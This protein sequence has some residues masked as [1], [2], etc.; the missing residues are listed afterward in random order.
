MS[1][2]DAATWQCALLE[3]AA[4]GTLL[5]FQTANER[6]K[7]KKWIIGSGAWLASILLTNSLFACPTCKEGLLENGQSGLNLARGFELSIY[8][9]LSAPLLILS[10]LAVAFYFQIR[11]A[12][13]AGTYPDL[14]QLISEAES[15]GRAGR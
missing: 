14:A 13:R 2:R 10:T 12:K 3:R 9:M 6:C 5:I 11:Q 8:L 1:Q 4:S 15:R 7:L